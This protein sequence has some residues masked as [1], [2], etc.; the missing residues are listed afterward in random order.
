MS[1]PPVSLFFLGLPRL[2][3]TAGVLSFEIIDVTAGELG[4]S[5]FVHFNNSLRILLAAVGVPKTVSIAAIVNILNLQHLLILHLKPYRKTLLLPMIGPNYQGD[6]VQR[7][8]GEYVLLHRLYLNYK[9][10]A[11]KI[12][13]Y[14][15]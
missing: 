7:L 9:F 12:R 10:D 6:I 8:Y 3:L 4:I 11:T 14:K 15:N 1:V 13:Q 5:K 2:P